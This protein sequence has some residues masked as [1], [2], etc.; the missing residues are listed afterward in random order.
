MNFT[1]IRNPV[2]TMARKLKIRVS[3]AAARWRRM[4]A[5]ERAKLLGQ[6]QKIVVN[7]SPYHQFVSKLA[8]NKS[9]KT[10]RLAWPL[11]ASGFA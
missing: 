10:R 9:I 11:L 6:C 1:A 7:M 8:K 3:V 5:N 2:A 4:N